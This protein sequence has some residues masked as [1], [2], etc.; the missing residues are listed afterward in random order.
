MLSSGSS[1]LDTGTTATTTQ[2]AELWFG[3]VAIQL[4]TTIT[5]PTNGFTMLDGA[6]GNYGYVSQAVVYKTVN[7]TG[8][9]DSGGTSGTSSLWVGCMATFKASSSGTASKLAYTAGAGQSVN[10]GSVSS[11][12]TVQVQASNGNPVTSGATV[13][14]ST[15]S[16]GGS[17]YSDSGGTNQIT[18]ITISSGQS[19]GN[20]Y[21]KDANAGTPT[22]TASST[23]LTSATTQ[24]TITS[25]GSLSASPPLQLS[26]NVISIPQAN[27]STNGYLASSDWT[28]FNGKQNALTAS[29][30]FAGLTLTGI[31]N[32]NAS[33]SAPVAGSNAGMI[34][35][36]YTYNNTDGL[37]IQNG[38]IWLKYDTIFN[39]YRDSGSALTNSLHLDSSGNA[40]LISL[41]VQNAAGTY[42]Y[43]GLGD[44]NPMFVKASGYPLGINH[45]SPAIIASNGTSEL[46][47]DANVIGNGE[48]VNYWTA[49]KSNG[50]NSLTLAPGGMTQTQNNTLDDSLGNMTLKAPGST[51]TLFASYQGTSYPTYLSAVTSSMEPNA[52]F[53]Q[54]Q[55]GI[56]AGGDISA[57]GFLGSS[58]SPNSQTG[59]G[60]GAIQLGHSYTETGDPAAIVLIDYPSPQGSGN[61]TLWLKYG[62]GSGQYMQNWPWGNLMLGDLTAT[63]QVVIT[64]SN[65][66]TTSSYG[67]LNSNGTTGQSIGWLG[68]ISLWAYY[69]IFCGGEIAVSSDQRDKNLVET[70]SPK[71]ALSAITKLNPLHF[72]WKPETKK[73]N[74]IVAGF[75][76]Q[77]VA[78][79]VP[80]AVT[81]Y[82][83]STHADE[84]T[85]NYNMLTTYALSAIQGLAKEVENLR[86]QLQ[87]ATKIGAS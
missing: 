19:S 21:Y 61:S 62:N 29:P 45:Q 55:Y 73:G 48:L 79:I 24:F 87:Q 36:C 75:F 77:E 46:L 72:A 3:A 41:D 80:E 1:A 84:H 28:T 69:G 26:G 4:Y 7:A 5:Y 10:V 11:V 20:F 58:T 30:T 6:A 12:I 70:L 51:I 16:S 50:T 13:G 35:D 60:G 9:A 2:A 68:N 85:L 18:S 83:S 34:L 66:M 33:G 25:S 32:S 52:P 37:G 63:G 65:P 76:A 71:T 53:I 78:E 31:L 14:L 15:S 86:S 44:T 27:G 49:L 56:T 47:F 82:K 43:I 74:N 67:Y 64:G 54:T 38:G 42:G 81:V 39:I 22:L 23:G 59:T 8:T 57:Y 40:T 17:F